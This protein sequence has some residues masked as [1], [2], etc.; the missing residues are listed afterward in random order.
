MTED[1]ALDV[2]LN[3]LHE[4]VSA[5]IDG[6]GSFDAVRAACRRVDALKELRKRQAELAQMQERAARLQEEAAKL[7]EEAQIAPV[8]KRRRKATS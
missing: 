8:S 3:D 1:A 5:H 6:E 4:A 7:T 2:K